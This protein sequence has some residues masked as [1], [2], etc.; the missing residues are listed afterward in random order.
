MFRP[1]NIS[2]GIIGLGYVGLPLSVAFAEKYTVTGFDINSSRITALNNHSDETGEVSSEDLQKF[3]VT[4]LNAGKNGLYLSSD[5]ESLHSCNVFII[6]VPT[7]IYANK[8]PDFRFL[9]SASETIGSILKKGDTVIYESTVYPGATEEECVPILEK[10]SGLA[11]N[12]DFFVGYSP[13]R[14]NPGDKKNTLKTIVKLTSGSNEA[15]KVFVNTLYESIIDAGTFPVS[16]IKVAEAAKVIENTQRDINIAFVNELSRIFAQ[17]NIPTQEV[18]KAAGTKW[19]FLKFVPGL[20]GG[21]CIGINPYFLVHKS[22]TLGYVPQLIMDG[23]KINESM[24]EFVAQ[25]IVLQLAK[26]K[27]LPQLA[28]V[29]ILGATFK[30]N[31]PDTRNSKVGN[32]IASLQEYEV[33]ISVYDPVAIGLTTAGVSLINYND[34]LADRQFDCI[35]L[36]VA[37]TEFKD[38]DWIKYLHSEGFIYDIKGFLPAGDRVIQL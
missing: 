7:L 34:E 21:H 25:Q 9:F 32:L 1:E 29:L 37:H 22:S 15:T 6:T 5:I 17:M 23:R 26:R 19:N 8:E 2:I 28:N 14:I 11:Y 36:A 27:I 10:V 12:I 31:C 38:T 35:V 3:I 20:V 24:P 18:L 4:H 30:E 13:E 33:N 16:S